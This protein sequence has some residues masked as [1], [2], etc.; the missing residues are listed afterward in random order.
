M[1]CWFGGQYSGS[2]YLDFQ[3]GDP[4]ETFGVFDPECYPP[5]FSFDHLSNLHSGLDPT[6]PVAPWDTAPQPDPYAIM[7]L[8]ESKVYSQNLAVTGMTEPLEVLPEAESSSSILDTLALA[9]EG[10]HDCGISNPCAQPRIFP[11]ETK[12]AQSTAMHGKTKKESGRRLRAKFP[13]NVKDTLNQHVAIQPYPSKHEFEELSS[14]TG[15]ESKRLRQWFSNK[16][17][18]SLMKGMC[19]HHQY[20][21]PCQEI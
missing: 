3:D 15:M 18:R 9:E 13:Q 1:D 16:R 14:Q 4:T 8:L 6:L 12:T 2:S 5:D 20:S 7:G 19:H 17:L 21:E 11:M 10:P